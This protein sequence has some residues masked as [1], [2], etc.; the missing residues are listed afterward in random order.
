[1]RQWHAPVILSCLVLTIPVRSQTPGPT[2]P[3]VAAHIVEEIKTAGVP[4][5]SVAVVVGD[6][7]SVEAVGVTD[8]EKPVPMTPTTLIPI[9]SLTKLLT[10]IGIVTVLQQRQFPLSSAVGR[11]M[12]GLQPRAAAATFHHLLSHT[13]GLRDEPGV[14]GSDDEAALASAARSLR[15]GD[16]LLPAGTVFSYS[17]LGY[18]LAGATFGEITKKPFADALRASV[19]DPLEMRSSSFRPDDAGKRPRAVG[20]RGAAAAGRASPIREDDNDTRLWPAGYL[21]SNADD[22]SKLLVAITS[23]GRAGKRPVIAASVLDAVTARHAAMPNVFAGGHYGYGLMMSADGAD[24]FFEHGGTAAGYSAILRVAPDRRM[25]FVIMTNLDNAPLRRIAQTVMSRALGLSP[26]PPAAR[27]ETAVSAEE[28]APFLGVYRNR[29][30]AEIAVRDGAPVL[31]LD[32]GPAM[33]IARIGS[34]RF[35]AR[36]KPGAGGPEFVLRPATATAPAYLHFALWA[37]TRP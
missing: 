31:V 12:P 37:F 35:I 22:M 28:V 7:V 5:A 11:H 36:V 20:H 27:E 6:S 16:F 2:A 30:T 29:G 3:G 21:W 33:T 14:D 9:G 25:A 15:D 18:A 19:L 34:D 4:G 24:R 10:A 17:N 26:P 32:G 13:S 1:M 8:T 23:R